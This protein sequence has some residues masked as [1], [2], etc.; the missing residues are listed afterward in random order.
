M[1]QVECPA[2]PVLHDLPNHSH[3][4]VE[5]HLLVM[6]SAALHNAEMDRQAKSPL[7][8]LPDTILYT[9]FFEVIT[10]AMLRPTGTILTN[11]NWSADRIHIPLW[12]GFYALIPLSRSCKH[13]RLQSQNFLSHWMIKY[14]HFS[15]IAGETAVLGERKPQMRFDM[16]PKIAVNTILQARKP[17]ISKCLDLTLSGSKKMSVCMPFEVGSAKI[18]PVDNSKETEMS[19][20][21]P[22]S[23]VAAQQI[24]E[25]I[26]HPIVELYEIQITIYPTISPLVISDLL[27]PF[28]KLKSLKSVSM[29]LESGTDSV[30]IERALDWLIKCNPLHC[31]TI[32]I[33]S[34]FSRDALEW[35]CSTKICSVLRSHVS[36]LQKL[37]LHCDTLTY[38]TLF[39][40][41]RFE[42]YLQYLELDVAHWIN[43]P[44]RNEMLKFEL[45]PPVRLEKMVLH[46]SRSCL[47][48]DLSL[49]FNP[50]R[51]VLLMG[52]YSQTFRDHQSNA[53]LMV[54]S[55]FSFVESLSVQ[56]M[57][58]ATSSISIYL[59]QISQIMNNL[60]FLELQGVPMLD[61]S[62][63]TFPSVQCLA[64]YI[65]PGKVSPLDVLTIC[66]SQ[67]VFPSLSSL[68]LHIPEVTHGISLSGYDDIFAEFHAFE[69]KRIKSTWV[70]EFINRAQ[71]L[72]SLYVTSANPCGKDLVELM[73]LNEVSMSFPVSYFI[74]R[75]WTS[76]TGER[77]NILMKPVLVAFNRV[78]DWEAELEGLVTSE[79]FHGRTPGC[80]CLKVW[81]NGST[82]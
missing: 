2:P 3:H 24:V 71:G 64:V 39:W 21:V 80:W 54:G 81:K 46:E 5:M 37:S 69:S 35:D 75:F 60:L 28:A 63:I 13:L 36:F 16:Y 73:E 15:I 31:V 1:V 27:F 14:A 29:K 51:L 30:H 47:Q 50:K 45:S 58:F 61:L 41:Y 62:D 78:P 66:E 55:R 68:V 20:S 18:Q 79:A 40:I 56:W 76:S 43:P 6:S 34:E 74:E 23:F 32:A 49:L 59:A 12:K 72:K 7:I 33:E 8:Y 26:F 67:S 10:S 70:Q 57:G 53:T 11:D 44:S 38:S 48:L 19:S 25:R 9:I 52:K 77:W 22:Y 65:F 82:L 4:E 17:L 42:K